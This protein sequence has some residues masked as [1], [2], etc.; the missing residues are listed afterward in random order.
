MMD[1]QRKIFIS[2]SRYDLAAVKAIKEELETN[3]FPCWMDL[4]GIESGEA[5]FKRVIIPAINGAAVF[6]F[7]LSH[8]SQQSEFALKEIEFAKA[9][10]KRIVLVRINDD[11]LTDYFLFDFQNSDIIDWRRSEQK[12][13][14]LY[15]LGQWMCA[16]NIESTDGGGKDLQSSWGE[17]IRAYNN[18]DKAAFIRNARA[19]ILSMRAQVQDMRN[20]L[21]SL[22]ERN[23]SM[24]EQ[25]RLTIEQSRLTI[26]QSK[27]FRHAGQIVDCPTC[28]KRN[29]ITDSIYCSACGRV[30]L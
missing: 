4:N 18:G 21:R 19:E 9:K 20:E 26:E 29:V 1:S 6:L 23:Q 30:L 13:K 2:Y 3:G 11:S 14:L 27:L 5:N 28:G 24:I 15:D 7:F 25:S 16:G 17:L 22:H 8:S 10:K 12:S